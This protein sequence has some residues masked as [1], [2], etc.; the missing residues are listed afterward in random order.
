MRTSAARLSLIADVRADSAPIL[1]SHNEIR[2]RA[3]TT[4]I[5]KIVVAFFFFSAGEL[6]KLHDALHLRERPAGGGF[7]PYQ[8]SFCTSHPSDTEHSRTA[9]SGPGHWSLRIPPQASGK[10]PTPAP[11]RNETMDSSLPALLPGNPSVPSKGIAA[12]IMPARYI[13]LYIYIFIITTMALPPLAAVAGS[14]H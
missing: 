6:K 1:L 13:Y 8:V 5:G 14:G 11:R 10:P 4:E 12:I 7:R 3:T 2:C 9:F